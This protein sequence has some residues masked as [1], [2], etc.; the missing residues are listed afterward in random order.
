ML[1]TGRYRVGP[2]GVKRVEAKKLVEYT[3]CCLSDNRELA[4]DVFGESTIA[5]GQSLDNVG[6]YDKG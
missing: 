1:R 3:R 5:L 4:A 6:R 2:S